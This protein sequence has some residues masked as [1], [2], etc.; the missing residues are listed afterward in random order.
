MT[1]PSQPSGELLTFT[2]AAEALD[3]HPATLRRLIAGGQLRAV[4]LWRAVR[5]PRAD[6]ARLVAHGAGALRR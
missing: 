6:V 5:I 4:R 3:V 2:Q 1:A